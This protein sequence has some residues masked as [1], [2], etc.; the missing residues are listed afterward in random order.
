MFLLDIKVQDSE[1]QAGI[2][3]LCLGV[4][5]EE[6]GFEQGIGLKINIVYKNY[7]ILLVHEF[8]PR[9][10][11]AMSQF[12]SETFL[13]SYSCVFQALL[14]ILAIL[15][16]HYVNYFLLEW[17]K[18]SLLA[19]LTSRCSSCKFHRRRKLCLQMTSL[20]QMLW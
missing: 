17:P 10:W 11:S 18:V 20:A 16:V 19:Q 15:G 5:V 14:P 8:L 3:N 12:C 13:G 4:T 7:F 9:I 2:I 6:W 1:F